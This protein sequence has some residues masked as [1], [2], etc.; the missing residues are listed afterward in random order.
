MLLARIVLSFA[1]L[2]TLISPAYAQEAN[3]WITNYYRHP[4]PDKLV[5]EVV[6]YGERGFLADEQ[7]SQVLCVFL[8][9]VMASHPDKID[10]WMRRL[11]GLSLEGKKTLTCAVWMSRTERG[12]AYL[13][14]HDC[15]E[16]LSKEPIDLLSLEPGEPVILDMLWAYFF[17]TGESAPVR[18][19][20][21]ALNYARY[22][23]SIDAYKG[24]GNSE[25]ARTNA[26]R[27]AVFKSALWSLTSNMNQHQRVAQ[28]CDSVFKK[29]ESL[30]Q[31]EKYWLGVAMSKVKGEKR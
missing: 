12:N 10:S 8:S 19:I 4:T 23:G 17:A 2:V 27:E 31:A 28:I 30:S 5:D 15:R 6:K 25:E 9:R 14:K 7:K 16:L 20:I 1:L 13:R 21:Y 22:S 11:D 29:D 26:Y 18:R 3:D 24:A